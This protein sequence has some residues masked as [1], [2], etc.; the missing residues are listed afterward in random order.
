[1]DSTLAVI[2]IWVG[3][4]WPVI[5]ATVFC[6]LNY[7]TMRRLGTFFWSSVILG[8]FWLYGVHLFSTT[9]LPTIRETEIIPDP[10]LSVLDDAAFIA[11]FFII[12]VVLAYFIAKRIKAGE[13]AAS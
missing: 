1:M 4:L 12:P 13:R 3:F 7:Y 5:V 11:L 10:L 9:V 8:Y 2:F 6:I